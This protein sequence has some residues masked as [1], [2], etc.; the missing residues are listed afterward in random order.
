MLGRIFKTLVFIFIFGSYALAL[1]PQDIGKLDKV[2]LLI[3]YRDNINELWDFIVNRKGNY[4]VIDLRV[5]ERYVSTDLFNYLRNWVTNGGGIVVYTGKDDETCS[6]CLFYP[7]I[8]YEELE[9]WES[10]VFRVPANLKNPVVTNVRK[11]MF[12]VARIPIIEDTT[13]KIVILEDSNGKP[14][15]FIENMGRGRVAF[16]NANVLVPYWKKEFYDNERLFL[17]LY[18]WLAGRN[19]PP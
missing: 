11:V 9:K 12:V 17:N 18:R 4:N 6:A 3:V 14:M 16:I 2:R 10:R 1:T 13:G 7:D 5:G 19:V 8:K 15:A